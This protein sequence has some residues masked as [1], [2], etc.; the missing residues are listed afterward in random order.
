MKRRLPCLLTLAVIMSQAIA[1][2]T[3]SQ[4]VLVPPASVWRYLDD[5]S[6]QGSAWTG[7]QFDDSAWPCGP[8][9]LGYGDA[10]DIRPEATAINGGSATNHFLTTYFRHAFVV[11]NL[12]AISN[13]AATL[14]C[15]DG[16]VV[17]LNGTEALRYNMP[18]GAI[19]YQT[20]ALTNLEG[21]AES[22]LVEA[23]LDPALL[24]DGTNVL[25]AEVHQSTNT[26]ADLSWEFMLTANRAGTHPLIYPGQTL[27][28]AISAAGEADAYS[29]EAA[30]N[31]QISVTMAKASGSLQP[32]LAVYGPG[33]ILLTNIPG[34]V[35]LAQLDGLRLTNDGTFQ[36]VCRDGA[37]TQTGGYGLTLIKHPQPNLADLPIQPGRAYTNALEV[38]DLDTFTFS[39]TN[40]DMISVVMAR[41]GGVFMPRISVYAPDGSRIGD[42]SVGYS[43]AEVSR[44]VLPQT[45][46][47]QVVCRD[48]YGTQ[49]GSYIV[50]LTCHR[51]T[52]PIAAG[53]TL[54]NAFDSGDLHTYA[55]SST[56]TER[57]TIHL[58]KTSGSISVT[59]S[60]YGP[61]GTLLTN[62]A[63]NTYS[64]ALNAFPLSQAGVYQIVCRDPTVIYTGTYAL[65]VVRHP[66]PNLGDVPVTPG[67]PV[68]N[69]FVESD[70]DTFTFAS[71]NGQRLN[72]TMGRVSGSI[73]SHFTLYA[74]DGS[75]VTNAF[76][77]YGRS[78]VGGLRFTNDGVYQ[79][80]CWD[81]NDA[82]TGTYYL[83]LQDLSETIPIEP[84]QTLYNT[85]TLA[86]MDLFTFNAAAGDRVSLQMAKTNGPLTVGFALYTPD[87]TLVGTATPNS[88]TAELDDQLLTQTGTYQIICRDSSD[89]GGGSGD[90]ALSLVK[91]PGPNF[92]DVFLQ[93]DQAVTNILDRGDMDTFMFSALPGARVNIIMAK[94]SGGS[95]L[96][97]FSLH[98]PNGTLVTNVSGGYSRAELT[99]YRLGQ[100][101]D[102]QIVCRNTSGTASE[103]YLLSLVVEGGGTILEPGQ[104]VTNTLDA[105]ALHSYLFVGGPGEHV[106]ILMAVRS[107]S[108]APAFT[109]YAPDETTLTNASGSSGAAGVDFVPLPQ[110]GYYQLV[111]R[112][113]NGTH[114]G[115]YA[116]TL[117]KHPGP[118]LGDTLIRPGQTLADALEIGDLDTFTFFGTNLDAVT[119][120]MTR[121]GTSFSPKLEFY[122]PD[123]SLVARSTGS[124]S[125]SLA[126]ECLD[127]S[128]LYV[129]LCRA[130]S[131]AQG[132]NYSLSLIYQAKTAIPSQ[133]PAKPYLV[134]HECG[135]VRYLQWLTNAA[136][137]QLQTCGS[138][139]EPP[140][141][142]ELVPAPYPVVEDRYSL[143]LGTPPT[144]CFYR[145]ISTNRP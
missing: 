130:V 11:T 33:G 107:G 135:G 27:T 138:V 92:G 127:Q 96:Q 71:T 31:E 85:I 123:G 2:P 36:I 66:G 8:A 48:S 72:I 47:Y 62:L 41:I 90:Y 67:L 111:C 22:L 13:L 133:D 19:D 143:P 118:N 144:N 125:A 94:L 10:V 116:V 34:G 128:G 30:A 132:G 91:H 136:T 26:S 69:T 7:R 64:V 17:Y 99:S 74:P 79:I 115:T 98:A 140:A 35:S 61:D 142:W 104:T 88:Y 28:N 87:E 75:W 59:L 82:V 21:A 86:E 1:W 68:T 23:S 124:S 46:L 122:R 52:I 101:G 5:G 24:V 83:R 97:N 109:V 40:G 9:E 78:V 70:L 131:G 110:S 3:L 53:E 139:D 117:I 81:A 20:A 113:V 55:Y 84:G 100:G 60:L 80:V 141:A 50:N 76:Y 57:V 106:T 56:G 103:T 95:I 102:Y 25:A 120:S 6:N 37:S 114:A 105:G 77:S 14:V 108:V 63:A 4:I 54:T 32:S 42:V 45:G 65:T 39:G 16:A 112:D 58:S 89:G 93:S 121:S 51:D 43:P 38:A 119:L 129:V 29:F 12:T 15:D 145:L 49:T 126:D 44:L 73:A 137:F 18:A 134:F